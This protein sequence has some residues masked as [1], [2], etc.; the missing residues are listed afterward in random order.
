[1]K[2][3]LLVQSYPGANEAVVRHWPYYVKSGADRI[4]GVGT[5]D[6]GCR[7]PAGTPV[8]NIG[9]NAY[10]KRGHLP[11]RLIESV[12]DGLNCG[13]FDRIVVIEYDVLFFNPLPADLPPGFNGQLAGGEIKP[14]KARNFY[15]SPWV[16]DRATAIDVVK[17]GR[18]LIS[19]GDTE[20]GNPDFFIGYLCERFPKTLKAHALAN[21]FT[22]NTLDI[23][24]KIEYARGL[25][26]AGNLVAVHGCKTKEQLDYLIT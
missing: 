20:F 18:K 21:C 4:V 13:D 12:N 5:D 3:V 15:H 24:E 7:W 14:M 22:Q 17:L 11:S 16:F 1:M 9:P 2:T 19:M 8:V 23:P 26:R 10:I 6:N 25:V